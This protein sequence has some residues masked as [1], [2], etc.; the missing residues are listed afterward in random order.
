MVLGKLLPLWG[1]TFPACE[2]EG[3]GPDPIF[4]K[5]GA[6]ILGDR[7]SSLV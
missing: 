7:H 5:R 2:R 6:K 3:V 4:Y 1:L